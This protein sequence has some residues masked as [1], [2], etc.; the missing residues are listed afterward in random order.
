MG[1]FQS[2]YR[3]HYSTETVLVRVLNDF[4]VNLDQG[5]GTLLALSIDGLR[6]NRP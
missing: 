1:K 6:Y 5:N 2:A 4:T 3:T